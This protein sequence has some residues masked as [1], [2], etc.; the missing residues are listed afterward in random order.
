MNDILG[1]QIQKKLRKLYL[2]DMAEY[3]EESL[4]NAQKKQSGHLA[5]LADLVDRQLEA[6]QRRSFERRLK[7]ADLPRNMTFENFDF[8]FQPGLNVE[9]LKDLMEL[10]FVANR[11]P[12]LVFGK[13]G[14]GKTHIASSLGIL[15]CRA[16]FKVKFH[17]LQRLLATLYTSLADGTT[18]DMITAL[19]R[20]DLLIIDNIGNIRTKQEY[21]SLLLDLVS[22]CR[23]NT[24]FIITSNISLEDWGNVMGDSVITNASIDRLLHQAHVINIRHGRSYRTEG[25]HAPRMPANISSSNKP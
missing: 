5:F 4:K 7:I 6:R 19:S 15:A 2:R 20:I 8:N 14:S 24:A 12:L 17:S 10:S 25:P 11:Q 3:L 22:T 9:Y 13:T 1:D 18:D 16:G 21:P 23:E